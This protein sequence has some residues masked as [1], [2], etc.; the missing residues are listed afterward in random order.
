VS[1][2]TIVLGRKGELLKRSCVRLA[3]EPFL[4]RRVEFQLL[5]ECELKRGAVDTALLS[6]ADVRP[7]ADGWRETGNAAVNAGANPTHGER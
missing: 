3:D 4:V 1:S 6:I 2:A 7:P 5:L